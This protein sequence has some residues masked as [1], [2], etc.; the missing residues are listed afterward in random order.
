MQICGKEALIEG[1]LIRIARLDAEGYQFLEDPEAALG[2]LQ[3]SG[4]RIDIF[5]FIQKL[6]ETSPKYSY[7]WNGTTW[8]PSVF[9]PSTSG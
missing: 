9:R 5:T 3:N 2:V 4:T 6:S 7:P 1:K 8:P